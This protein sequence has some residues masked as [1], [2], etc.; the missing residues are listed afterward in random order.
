MV[1]E[2]EPGLVLWGSMLVGSAKFAASSTGHLGMM[3]VLS[4][5]PVLVHSHT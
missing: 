3:T 5:H 4:T 2:T 1:P